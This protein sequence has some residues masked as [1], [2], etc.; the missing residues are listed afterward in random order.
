MDNSWSS[1]EV[2]QPCCLWMGSGREREPVATES[3]AGKAQLVGRL[4][5]LSVPWGGACA[6]LQSPAQS[7]GS[8]GDLSSAG[9]HGCGAH[10]ERTVSEPWDFPVAFVEMGMCQAASLIGDLARSC[11][12]RA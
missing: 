3:E 1:T 7:G 8:L 2:T 10:C 5:E 4:L 9:A 12:S 6:A 11:F